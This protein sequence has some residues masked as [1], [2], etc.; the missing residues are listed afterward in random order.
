MTKRNHNNL[1][2]KW[3]VFA[4]SYLGDKN[5]NATK[6]YR[7]AYPNAAQRSAE[8]EAAKL[9]RKPEVANYIEKAQ[10]ARSERTQINADYVLSRLVE[11]DQM[12]VLDILNDD[13]SLKPISEWPK[14]WRQYLA[15]MDLAELWEGRDDKRKTVGVLKKIKWPDKL[16]NLELLG[17]H[18]GVQAFRDRVNH[19]GELVDEMATLMQQISD[20]ATP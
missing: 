20:G 19:E 13:G 11:I 2:E 4:D 15:G 8:V 6:A 7:L 16:K 17:K 3:Q 18:I 10:R 1:T 9:L 14:V 5:L 12:D